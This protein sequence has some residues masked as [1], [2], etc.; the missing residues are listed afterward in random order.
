MAE[1]LKKGKEVHIFLPGN[2][3]KVFKVRRRY[4]YHHQR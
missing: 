4:H 3:S 2:K 1:L